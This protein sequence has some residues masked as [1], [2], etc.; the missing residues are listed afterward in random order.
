MAVT[1]RFLCMTVM[2]VELTEDVNI[3]FLIMITVLFAYGT[4]NFFTK[5]FFSS[6]IELRKLPFCSKLMKNDVYAKTAKDVMKKPDHFLTGQS[7]LEDIYKILTQNEG[8]C[9]G[10]FVPVIETLENQKFLGTVKIFNLVKYLKTELKSFALLGH[11]P[12]INKLQTLLEIYLFIEEEVSLYLIHS[13]TQSRR[14]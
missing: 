1:T 6:N 3:I 13:F 2:I 7:K 11:Q 9:L 14:S 5:S 12:W 8:I 10:D 4:G